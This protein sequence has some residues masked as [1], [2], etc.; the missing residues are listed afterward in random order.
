MRPALVHAGFC[1]LCYAASVAAFSLACPAQEQRGLLV[2]DRTKRL[3]F[4]VPEKWIYD[5]ASNPEALIYTGPKVSGI[6]SRLTVRASLEGRPYEEAVARFLESGLDLSP[7]DLSTLEPLEGLNSNLLDYGIQCVRKVKSKKSRLIVALGRNGPYLVSF[8]FDVAAKGF[9]RHMPAL[10]ACL[11]SVAPSALAPVYT[12]L[13]MGIAFYYMPEGCEVDE[14]RTREGK[15]IVWDYKRGD[16]DLGSINTE[17][18]GQTVTG[19]E[20]F[21]A[22]MTQIRE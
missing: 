3:T 19:E 20:E 22:L 7:E 18:L 6:Q 8:T 10:M 17:I 9:D 1:I 12:D 2:E 5:P 14:K 4:R 15:S 21:D 16:Q 13:K 11:S